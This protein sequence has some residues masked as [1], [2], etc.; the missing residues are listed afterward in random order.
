MIEHKRRSR[1]RCLQ[2]VFIV[3]RFVRGTL[4]SKLW[5][6]FRANDSSTWQKSHPIWKCPSRYDGVIAQRHDG[7]VVPN[8]VKWNYSIECFRLAGTISPVGSCNCSCGNNALGK[9]SF[10]KCSHLGK[11]IISPIGSCNCSFGNIAFGKVSFSKCSF[12]WALSLGTWVK[13]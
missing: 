12:F 6:V 2:W 9:V 7:H 4:D 13:L 10:S 1:A 3:E 5:E 11:I 8:T